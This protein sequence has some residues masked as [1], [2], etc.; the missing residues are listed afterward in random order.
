[1]S[2][3]RERKFKFKDKLVDLEVFLLDE[4]DIYKNYFENESNVFGKLL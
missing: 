4:I 3:K 2:D 1:M